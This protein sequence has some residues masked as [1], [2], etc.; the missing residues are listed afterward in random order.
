[1]GLLPVSCIA[2]VGNSKGIPPA[3]LIPDFI[4]SDKSIKYYVKENIEKNTFYSKK[5]NTII[6]NDHFFHNSSENP[7]VGIMGKIDKSC[8]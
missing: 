8:L 2:W 7:M 6:L 4:L 3:S 1:M 5:K